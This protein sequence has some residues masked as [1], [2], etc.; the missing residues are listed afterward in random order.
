VK[1][2]KPYWNVLMKSLQ[3][4]IFY[5]SMKW[6][7]ALILEG[8]RDDREAKWREREDYE[9]KKYGNEMKR[10]NGSMKLLKKSSEGGS[11]W[12]RRKWRNNENERESSSKAVKKK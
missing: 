5:Y 3:T 7:R 4:V 12:P 10:G 8:S 9:M 6:R 2:S 1:I 11:M